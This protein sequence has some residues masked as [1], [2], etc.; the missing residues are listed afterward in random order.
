MQTKKDSDLYEKL[1]DYAESDFYPF[2]M[3]GHKRRICPFS[4]LYQIDIT[5]IDGFDNLHHAEGILLEAQKRAASLY[6]AEETHFLINGSSGGILAAAAA[7]VPRNGT[8]L[9]ARNCHKAVYHAVLLN[10]FDAEYLYPQPDMVRGI[11]GAVNPEEVRE[12]LER[13]PKIGAVLIT[14]PTYDGVVSDVKKIAEIV[15]RS[16]IPLIVDEAHGAHFGMHP[17]FP[18]HS[19]ACG[20]DIV[21]NSAHKTLPALTQ[22]AFL[23]VQGPLVDRD[24]LRKYLEIYQTSSPSYVLMAGLDRCVRILSVQ[25]S[26]LFENFA[27]RLERLRGRLSGMKVLH[28]VDGSEKELY[29]YDYDRSK[30]IISLENCGFGGAWLADLLRTRYHLE[31]EMDAENYIT[32]ITTLAD[33]EQGLDR[34]ADALLEIDGELDGNGSCARYKEAAGGMPEEDGS[35]VSDRENA[36][37]ETEWIKNE[38]VLRIADAADAERHAVSLERSGGCISAEFVYLYPPGIPLLAPGERIPKGLPGHLRRLRKQGARLQG[39]AD[40]EAEKIF[41]ISEDC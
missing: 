23:H 35:S 16:G 28:L 32:A 25:G 38:K 19:L 3:P 39:L 36:G 8:I 5:E 12:A 40:Y 29:C 33:S 37:R 21:I 20:A 34:L 41:V 24:R 17:Y 11:N 1:S 4:E 13:N 31:M 7:A 10:G 14:S 27:A 26:E 18:E 22:T 6:H 15:H 9:I 30:I 2:H